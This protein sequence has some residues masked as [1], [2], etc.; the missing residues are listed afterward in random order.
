MN[1]HDLSKT[2]YDD[3]TSYYIDLVPLGDFHEEFENSKQ[4]VL[5]LFNSIPKDRWEFR[6]EPEKWTLK[7]LLQHMI[8]TERVFAYRALRFARYDTTVIPGFEV[9]DY[10]PASKANRRHAKDLIEE[11]GSV[12]LTTQLLFKSFDDEMLLGK[13][14]ASEAVISVRAAGFK[15]IGHDIHHCKIIRERYV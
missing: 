6:Y 14:I 15:L 11:F 10:A 4:A 3:Y 12:R 8:D 1:V 2:E 13:G 7:E 5:T 9:E